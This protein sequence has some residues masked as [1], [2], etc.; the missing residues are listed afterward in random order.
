MKITKRNVFFSGMVIVCFAY[1]LWAQRPVTVIRAMGSY[2]YD[3]RF[4]HGLNRDSLR[5]FTDNDFYDI[6][7]DHMPLSEWGRIKWYLEHKT[8][9]K[10][11]YHIPT[12]S[13]YHIYFWDIGDGFIDGNKS[14]DGDLICINKTASGIDCLEKNLLLRVDLEKGRSEKFTFYDCEHYWMVMPDGR[15]TLF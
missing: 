15:L 9:L 2:E 12:S 4:M 14:G 8:E 1:L 7:V 5:G 3:P 11:K 6:V 10:T 13:S